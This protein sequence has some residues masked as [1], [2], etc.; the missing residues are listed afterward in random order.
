[1]AQ[2]LDLVGIAEIAEMIGVTRQRVDQLSRN[3]PDFPE[4]VAELHAGRIWTR[5]D[6][7][8]WAQRAGRLN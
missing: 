7:L 1:V 8:Q 5:H 4:P 3:D 2:D 6:V